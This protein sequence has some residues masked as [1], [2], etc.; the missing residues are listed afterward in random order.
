MFDTDNQEKL[1]R[2]YGEA[3]AF[4]R[5]VT[6]IEDGVR[7]TKAVTLSD[8]KDMAVEHLVLRRSVTGA[9]VRPSGRAIEAQGK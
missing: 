5:T 4:G 6:D 2:R 7:R 3:L 1:A 9:L 8:I